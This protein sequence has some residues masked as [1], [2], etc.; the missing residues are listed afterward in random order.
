[1]ASTA[2]GT[3]DHLVGVFELVALLLGLVLEADREGQDVSGT[4]L[5]EQSNQQA[6]IETAGE[7]HADRHVGD[8]QALVDRGDERLVHR[9]GPLPLAQFPFRTPCRES[10]VDLLR[11][12]WSLAAACAARRGW[13]VAPGSPRA[14]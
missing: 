9:L 3:L 11:S 14:G 10:P 7:Q 12:A 8:T 1:M 5:R 4:G 6:R 2:S 13:C